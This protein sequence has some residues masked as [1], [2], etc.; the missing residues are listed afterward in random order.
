MWESADAEAVKE[1]AH[2]DRA[3]QDLRDRDD[4]WSP[5]AQGFLQN[6]LLL[7]PIPWAAGETVAQALER[8]QIPDE[9]QARPRAGERVPLGGRELVWQEHRSPRA[10]VDFNAAAGRLTER[11]VAYAI[12]YIESDRERDD[13]WLQAGYDDWGKVY[14]NSREIHRARSRR[15]VGQQAAVGPVQLNAG[16]NALMLKVVN[17]TEGWQGSARLVDEAGRPAEG[18]RVTL[19]P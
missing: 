9:A 11:S 7:L 15:F 14:L 10:V 18:L 3:V 19:A 6:W 8:P 5:R 4:C 12:C 1:W 17:E 16:I 13:L 2:Q